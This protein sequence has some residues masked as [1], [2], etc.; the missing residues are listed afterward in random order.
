M[1]LELVKAEKSF[2]KVAA[3]R[4]IDLALPSGAKVALIG[5]NVSG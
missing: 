1:K 5:P 3:L 4:A 2:G